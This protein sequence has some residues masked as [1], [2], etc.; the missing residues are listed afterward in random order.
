M[1]FKRSN[2]EELPTEIVELLLPIECQSAHSSYEMK[3]VNLTK[4]GR[5][6]SILTMKFN[7]IP[8]D[9][10]LKSTSKTVFF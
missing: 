5:N 7:E 6:V 3:S 1:Y 10:A 8:S 9:Y 4:N 2:V